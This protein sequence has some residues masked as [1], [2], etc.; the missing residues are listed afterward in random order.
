MKSFA[1]RLVAAIR[2]K[3]SVLMVGIDPRLELLPPEVLRAAEEPGG[4]SLEI[5]ERAL[6]RFGCDIIEA[7]APYAVAVKPQLAYFEPYG[8][9]GLRAYEAVVAAARKAGLLVVADGKRND[10]GPTAEAYAAAFLGAESP[11]AA[12]A[13]TVNPYLGEDG[14]EPFLSLA[15]EY[16]KGIFVLV[17]TS[18]PSSGQFQDLVAD[19]RPIYEHVAAAVE[20][21]STPHG[22]S[23]YGPAG[24]VVG[25]TYPEQLRQL[26]TA[27][28]HAVFLVPGFG[29]QGGTADDVVGAFDENGLG[30][31]VNSSR[32]VIFAY[33][34]AG[35]QG[36]D[37]REALAA[38]ARTARDQL[39][40]ALQRAGRGPA[41]KA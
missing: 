11:M 37:Y 5:A 25:A 17:K 36:T 10:I 22:E 34:D 30:A 9:H 19:G 14:V 2:D 26:R 23:G 1:D 40:A 8:S 18:N 33:R 20:R 12:D 21:W 28:P 29:A 24:A 38:A 27:M 7:V 41:G 13:V 39:N 6:T 31:V 16:G 15:R 4:S 35:W 3:N 32:Q